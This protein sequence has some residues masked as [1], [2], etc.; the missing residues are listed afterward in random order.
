VIKPTTVDSK[1]TDGV[2]VMLGHAVMGKLRVQE[3]T[4]HAPLRGPRVEDQ[5]GRCVVA[6]PY[7]LAAA[8]QEVQDPVSDGGV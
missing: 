8:H 4:K 3:G 1:L 2:G 6:Y 5:R 7:H